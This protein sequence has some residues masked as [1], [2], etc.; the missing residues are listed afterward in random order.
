MSPTARPSEGVL[1][2]FGLGDALLR[3]HGGQ[4]RAWLVDG[5]V[6]KP[7]EEPEEWRWLAEH[8]PHAR[9]EGFRLARAIPAADG[10]WVVE[11]WCAQTA[12]AG[13][14]PKTPRWP[15]VLSVC[16]RFH[17]AVRHLPRPASL[18]ARD[19]PWSAGD[20]AAWEEA[21]P[22]AHPLIDRLVEVRRDVTQPPQLVPGDMT[23]NVL[24]A[25]GRDP[26]V[27]DISPYWRPAGFASAIVVADALCWRDA[28]PDQLL[29]AV[30]DVAKFPQLLV[31]ALIYRM[32]TS[33][34]VADGNPDL[35]GYRH[36]AHFAIGLTIGS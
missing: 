9:T 23:E 2:A 20:R 17:H 1:E 29:R 4:G 28:D 5:V 11:G 14:H 24:F 35:E 16:R 25:P 8:L 7:C 15:G 34:V 3:R 22:P 33:V 10:R 36:T 27:I 32:T 19:N 31:R 26:A 12:V 18:D 13:D 30:A 21:V 6:L